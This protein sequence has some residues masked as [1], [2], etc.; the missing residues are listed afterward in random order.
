MIDRGRGCVITHM[1]SASPLRIRTPPCDPESGEMIPTPESIAKKE[2]KELRERVNRLYLIV[3][4]MCGFM[5]LIVG[6]LQQNIPLTL[7]GFIFLII[8]F[9]TL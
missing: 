4:V 6:V 9:I 8:P 3:A 2:L 5:Y 1:D 7:L